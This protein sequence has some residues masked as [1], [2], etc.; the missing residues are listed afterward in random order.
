ME[1]DPSSFNRLNVTDTCAIWN[2]LSSR[3]L[4]DASLT[5][6]C[7]FSCT[8][9]VEYECL[10]RK[11]SAETAEDSALKR[12]FVR[13]RE[14]EIFRVCHLELEDLNDVE[15]LAKRKNLGKGELSS[16]AFANRTRQ[17]FLTDDKKARKLAA[18]VLGAR[19]VQT[20]PHLLG[21]LFFGDRLVDSDVDKIVQEH[22][23]L[24]RPLGRYFREMYR[25]ALRYRS[26]TASKVERRD[27]D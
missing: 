5:A 22:R 8:A 17:A 14:S 19:S 25:R 13:A 4:F 21:W 10:H 9:F 15:I 3:I 2:V 26:M 23:S 18:E 20:T 27:V 6:Q 1:I 7:Y 24:N 16:I 11:R 12:R